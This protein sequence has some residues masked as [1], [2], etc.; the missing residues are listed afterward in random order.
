MSSS[1]V[2]K[3]FTANTSGAGQMNDTGFKARQ[4]PDTIRNSNIVAAKGNRIF[5]CKSMKI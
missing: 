2:S 5:G 3:S 1:D 4:R